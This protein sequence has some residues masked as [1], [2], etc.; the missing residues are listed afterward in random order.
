MGKENIIM[1][2]ALAMVGIQ[3][4]KWNDDFRAR[5]QPSY[6]QQ[7][8]YLVPPPSPTLNVESED[9][10]GDDTGETAEIENAPLP[11]IDALSPIP[12][13]REYPPGL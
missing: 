13:I 6:L 5:E 11:A 12:E 3:G 7:P 4:C 2:T 10:Q 1:L 8:Q 9:Y